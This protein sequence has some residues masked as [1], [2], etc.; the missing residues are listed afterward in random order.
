MMLQGDEPVKRI[1]TIDLKLGHSTNN[2]LLGG[3]PWREGIVFFG[4]G[5]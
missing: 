5:F 1:S 3:L 4:R 2:A